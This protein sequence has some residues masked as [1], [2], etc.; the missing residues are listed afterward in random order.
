MHTIIAVVINTD[1][2]PVS[3]CRYLADTS[4]QPLMLLLAVFVYDPLTWIVSL[5]LAAD[6]AR[7]AAVLFIALARQSGTRCQ[8]NLEIRSFDGFKQF[9]K[10]I[11][12]IRYNSVTSEIEAY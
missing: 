1:S 9:L 4:S 6:L 3:A 2:I 7:T 12:F 5:F 11:I 10:T 8:M